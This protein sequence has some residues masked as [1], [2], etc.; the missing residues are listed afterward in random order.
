MNYPSSRCPECPLF[1]RLDYFVPGE[2]VPGAV[3]AFVGEAPGKMEAIAKRPFVG[4]AGQTHDKM[5]ETVHIERSTTTTTNVLKCW[6]KDNKLPDDLQLAIDCCSEILKKDVAEAK[7]IVGLGNVPLKA[8]TG[9]D[10]ITSRRGSIYRLNERQVFL[11]A[12]HPSYVR[13]LGFIKR[14]EMKKKVIPK[15]VAVQ[16]LKRA[17][18]L[19]EGWQWEQKHDYI[20]RPTQIEK[21]DFIADLYKP[22]PLVGVDIES[23]KEKETPLRAIPLIIAFSLLDRTLCASFEDDL[24][25]IDVV[26]RSPTP[27]TLHGGIFDMTVLRNVG[28]RV[29]NW[30]MDTLYA[31]HLEYAE[32]PHDLGF[33][34]SLYTPL[35]FH[36]HM[37]DKFEE[38]WGK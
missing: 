30:T 3:L 8:F 34:Q 23:T 21:D 17:R 27:K 4:P 14:D 37:K 29:V 26:L 24:D 16:D 2:V 11:A 12:L 5:L 19:A 10:F 20:I 36:K 6:P 15:P 33:V 22:M 18:Q 25:F 32:L 9:L 28:L 38:Q 31:H 13:R 7:V 1:Y 35:A